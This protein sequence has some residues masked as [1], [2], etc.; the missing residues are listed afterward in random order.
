MKA[1][2]IA[3]TPRKGSIISLLKEQMEIVSRAKKEI[4]CQ[5]NESKKSQ[6]STIEEFVKSYY[7]NIS[8]PIIATLTK[9]EHTLPEIE[10]KS[11]SRHSCVATV[12]L[13]SLEATL[14]SV[15]NSASPKRYHRYLITVH[16]NTQEIFLKIDIP[17]KKSL[18]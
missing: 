1:F 7:P 14:E 3:A 4:L 17:P 2:K 18:K 8:T 13:D 5:L 16:L 6:F 15:N 9:P 12:K 11:V 10:D